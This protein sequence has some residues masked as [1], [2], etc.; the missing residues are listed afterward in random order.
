MTLEMALDARHSGDDFP[1]TLVRAL[2][3][4]SQNGPAGYALRRYTGEIAD[5]ASGAMASGVRPSHRRVWPSPYLLL[6]SS[7]RFGSTSRLSR[8]EVFQFMSVLSNAP[9]A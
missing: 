2:R 1:K 5:N 4:R 6:V 8:R 9:H 7:E 3:W